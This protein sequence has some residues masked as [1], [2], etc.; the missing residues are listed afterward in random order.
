[1]RIVSLTFLIVVA[2][3]FGGCKFSQKEKDAM[4]A[5]CESVRTIDSIY[6]MFHGFDDAKIDEIEVRQ[7]RNG[8]VVDTFYFRPV[9]TFL[10]DGSGQRVDAHIEREFN[11]SDSYIFIVAGE[12]FVVS[13]MKMGLTP[14]FSMISEG[15]GCDLGYMLINGKEVNERFLSFWKAGY[16][17]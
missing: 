7:M 3:M 17:D 10:N 13:D 2:V 15:Y 16:W 8:L 4:R 1:M 14:Q 6:A 12:Q 9:I 11:L 5:E